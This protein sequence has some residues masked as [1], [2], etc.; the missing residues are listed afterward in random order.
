[1]ELLAVP[2][3]RSRGDGGAPCPLPPTPFQHTLTCAHIVW[4]APPGLQGE[5]HRLRA[6]VA[7][8]EKHKSDLVALNTS[9]KD[10]V[11]ACERE[12]HASRT[13]GT[14]SATAVSDMQERLEAAHAGLR[15]M[16]KLLGE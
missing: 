6:V 12:V 10:R 8:V 1:M 9:L 7:S 3:G 2:C 14:H 13:Q 5:V 16:A 11:V 15:D 4:L